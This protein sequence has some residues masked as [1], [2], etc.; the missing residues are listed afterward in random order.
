MARPTDWSA[1]GM[2][3][4]PVPG[5]PA[6]IRQSASS[7]RSIEQAIAQQVE[8]LNSLKDGEGWESE[9]GEKFRDSAGDLA[10]AIEKAKGRYTQLAAALDEWANGL[11]GLQREADA[12]L[13][14]AQDAQDAHRA[15]ANQTITADAD[16]PEHQDQ[17][18]AQDR[19]LS[20]AQ[21]DID[22]AKAIVRRIGGPFGEEGEYGELA[23][24]VADR[25]RQGADDGLKD[26]WFD[27]VK[28]AIHGARGVLNV[29]KDALDAVGTVLLVVTVVAAIF[30]PAALPVI[31]LIGL[32]VAGAKLLI[33][34]TQSM[35]GD[36][37]AGD[38]GKDAIGFA[39]AAVGFGAAKYASSAMGMLRGA[40]G[41]TRAAS[42]ATAARN[43]N[44]GVGGEL[45]AF[46]RGGDAGIREAEAIGRKPLTAFL[47]TFV[48]GGLMETAQVLKLAPDSALARE[49]AKHAALANGVVAG[50]G[51]PSLPGLPE[52][53]ENVVSAGTDW[54]GYW[55]SK[56]EIHVG[57]L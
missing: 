30:F 49:A 38:V 41:E 17:V 56:S 16:T 26:G 37:S 3:L 22:A 40:V 29:I 21:G 14:Q 34:A 31:A 13:L 35:A 8:R 52:S 44:A 25:I 19:A 33:T 15:A 47:D 24:R 50:S 42:A 6:E 48:T 12:A 4:D 10:G 45:T 27:H 20:A 2:Q 7:A 18:D 28:Q 11:E 55:K 39:L 1:V 46:L 57:S 43:S 53:V 51:L 36:A 32:A 54:D 9:S 5:D 23:G